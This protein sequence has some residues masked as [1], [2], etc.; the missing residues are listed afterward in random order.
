MELG[1][2][3]LLVVSAVILEV[4]EDLRGTTGADKN[5]QLAPVYDVKDEYVSED[6]AREILSPAIYH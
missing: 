1:F 6:L 3:S 2:Q 5:S 4:T